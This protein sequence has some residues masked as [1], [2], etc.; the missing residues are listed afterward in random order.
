MEPRPICP[1]VE[2][3]PTTHLQDRRKPPETSISGCLVFGEA[4]P[5][6]PGEVDVSDRKEAIL[7]RVRITLPPNGIW[8]EVRWN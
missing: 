1:S 4:S 8:D 2:L 6:C 5:V 7:S 3:L